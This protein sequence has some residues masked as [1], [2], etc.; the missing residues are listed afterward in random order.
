MVTDKKVFHLEITVT[1]NTRT[2]RRL[3]LNAG[4]SY[5]PQKDNIA[6]SQLHARIPFDIIRD[7]I[8]MNLQL[9]ILNF[10]EA[11]FPGEPTFRSID[12]II[13]T[14]A[15]RIR[16]VITMRSQLFDMTGQW[17][18]REYGME[19]AQDFDERFSQQ[20]GP[21][22]YGQ[23][24]IEDLPNNLNFNTGVD[25][26]NQVITYERV[27]FWG[28]LSDMIR[29]GGHSDGKQSRGGKAPEIAF[30]RRKVEKP[31]IGMRERVDSALSPSPSQ[32]YPK[33]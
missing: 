21:G 25:F 22:T 19:V 30:G 20:S 26:I 4:Q 15:C 3:F 17:L 27:L 29:N 12:G 31:V 16:K 33:L 23:P 13:I 2:K 1:D 32:N 9:D 14:G 18:Q 28:Y 10:Y 8:W 7:G 11:C 6:K 24:Q 5:S